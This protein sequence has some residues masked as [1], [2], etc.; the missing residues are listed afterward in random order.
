M[1]TSMEI[2]LKPMSLAQEL[3]IQ[4]AA[5]KWS[6]QLPPNESLVFM[7]RGGP[8]GKPNMV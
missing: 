2:K 4:L 6:Q 5:L 3:R 1:P 7:L 8:I